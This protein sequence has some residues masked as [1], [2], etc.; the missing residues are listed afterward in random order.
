MDKENVI[1]TYNR[2]LF[3]LKKR[4]KILPFATTWVNLDIMLREISQD[5]YFMIPIT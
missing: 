4:K 1:N 2:I 5:K 3:G